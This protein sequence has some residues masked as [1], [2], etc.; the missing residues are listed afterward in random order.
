LNGFPLLRDTKDGLSLQQNNAN[1]AVS[2]PSQFLTQNLMKVILENF[3]SQENSYMIF[4][5]V[6]SQS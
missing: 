5:E 2:P 1:Q 3:P 6:C 4:T